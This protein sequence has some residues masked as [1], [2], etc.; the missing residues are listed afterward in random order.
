MAVTGEYI[1]HTLWMVLIG[2]RLTMQYQLT[3][4]PLLQKV[5]SQGEPLEEILRMP[6]IRLC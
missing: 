5:E 3:L 1:T 4:I 2:R 6:Q